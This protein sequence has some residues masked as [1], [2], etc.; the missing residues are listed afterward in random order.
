MHNR[1]QTG[2]LTFFG[3]YERVQL[4]VIPRDAPAA[5]I[6]NEDSATLKLDNQKNSHKRVC[7][8]QEANCDLFLCPVCALGGHYLHLQKHGTT[9]TTSLSTYF[10]DTVEY[11]VTAENMTRTLKVA[12]L[13]LQ[14]PELK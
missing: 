5:I 14:C 2:R 4:R 7:V 3:Y 8:H 6:A 10:I 11:K 9:Q 1:V 13:A 12:A